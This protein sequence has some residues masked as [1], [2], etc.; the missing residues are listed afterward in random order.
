MMND[1]LLGISGLNFTRDELRHPLVQRI[2]RALREERELARDHLE[3]PANI[4]QT[5]LQRGALQAVKKILAR[6]DEVGPESRQS[7][8]EWP[9]SASRASATHIS[10]Y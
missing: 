4:E 5:T 9:E 2:L 8:P 6:A 3:S 7:E 1:K 10:G